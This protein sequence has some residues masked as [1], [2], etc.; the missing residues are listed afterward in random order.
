MTD[1]A[2]RLT[3]HPWFQRSVV[4]LILL[5]AALVAAETSQ[6][7]VS[8][9]GALLALLQVV[10]I[11]AFVVELGLRLLA[12][13]PR[14]GAFFRDGW[15]LFDVLVVVASLVPAVGPLA[16]VGRLARVLR[17]ARL[18]SASRELRLIV[19]T[20]LRSVPSLG[21]VGLLLGLL[22]FIYGVLGV[23][24][25]R[26]ADPAHFGSLGAALLTLFQ[27][28]TLEGWVEIQRGVSAAHPLA[29]LYFGSFILVA[30]FVVVNLFIAV[31]LNNLEQ[32]RAELQRERD[33]AEGP[34][35]PEPSP[36]A[37]R[38]AE[39]AA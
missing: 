4:G 14:L 31:V 38:T 29:W 10:V 13:W 17:V 1:L 9:A 6:A 15:N 20:M 2:R 26:A 30:V 7:L 22:L 3:L 19:G 18:V 16:T 28:L 8:R 27:I 39:E 36:Q 5:S 34:N 12:A 32:V 24:W 37:A 25:F 35:L 23:H 21:H 33:T 11:A